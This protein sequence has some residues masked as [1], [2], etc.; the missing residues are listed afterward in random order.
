MIGVKNT[1]NSTLCKIFSGIN[2]AKYEVKN[3]M[4]GVN[5]NENHFRPNGSFDT[6]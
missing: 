5:S 2:R 1:A 3:E 4:H 6:K